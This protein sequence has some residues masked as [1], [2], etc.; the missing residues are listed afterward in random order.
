MRIL[1]VIHSIDPR[2]GGPSHALRGMV[3]A[4]VDRGNEVTVLTTTVQSAEPWAA[5]EEYVE[6]MR[7]EPCFAG[8]ELSIQP[9][10]GRRR[11]WSRFAYTPASARWLWRRLGDGALRP[12]VVHIHGIFSHVTSLAARQ[13]RR[14]G[15]PYIVR[16][17]GGLDARCVDHGAR[18]LKKAF[19]ARY[20]KRDLQ[21]AACVQAMSQ[22]EESQLCCWVRSERICVVPHGITPVAAADLADR[23][24]FEARFPQIRGRRYI[25]FLGRLH[26]IKRPGLLVEALAELHRTW[27][28]LVL[29][30][31]GHDA[32]ALDDVRSKAAT[33]GIENCII[34]TGF[35]SGELKSSALRAAEVFVLP[36]AHENFG[37]AVTEAMAHSTPV[38]VTREVGSHEHVDTSGCGLTVEGTAPAIA[39]GLRTLLRQD[40]QLLGERGRRYVTEHLTWDAVAVR[41]EEMYRSAVERAATGPDARR[42]PVVLESECAPRG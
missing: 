12:D 40:R 6:R 1:H 10:Y 36:S 2:S 37:V 4:Q 22:A 38:L 5:T 19:L 8:V 7:G 17:A 34:P 41:L 25:L 18:R 23:G 33:L 29:I 32:G 42:R 35:L 20:T 14:C 15:I 30:I 26:P 3:R 39:E 11:P 9:A 31:A 24:L 27:P 28:D 16:P 13:A 21:H